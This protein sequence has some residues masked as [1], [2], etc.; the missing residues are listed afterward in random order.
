MGYGLWVMGYATMTGVGYGL[1]VMLPWIMGY[2]AMTAT[3][4][5]V[6]KPKYHRYQVP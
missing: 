5:K 1:W 6:I 4:G 2:A 3:M